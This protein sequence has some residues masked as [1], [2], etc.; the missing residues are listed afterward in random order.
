LSK[1]LIGADIPNKVF[2]DLKPANDHAQIFQTAKAQ[3]L[4]DPKIAGEPSLPVT[5]IWT[6]KRILSKLTYL[7]SRF[8][9]PRMDM[10]KMYKIPPASVRVYFC[11]P[12]RFAGVFL[13]HWSSFK[14]LMF[15][16]E[17]NNLNYVERLDTLERWL[18]II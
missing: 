9:L 18:K 7:I 13:R 14:N 5:R 8:F 10:A 1:D 2:K 3:I 6:H 12:I 16:Q 17:K 11:Y 4:S 15:Q